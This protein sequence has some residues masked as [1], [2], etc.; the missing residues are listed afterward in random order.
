MLPRSQRLRASAFT[1]A[2]QNGRVLRHPLFQ[3]RVYRRQDGNL[4]VRAAFVAPKKLGKATLRNRTRRRIGE[5]YRLSAAQHDPR[6]Q[7]CDL[8]FLAAAAAVT[9]D[10]AQLDDAITQLLARAAHTMDVKR[11]PAQE[12]AQKGAQDETA[13]VLRTSL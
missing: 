8:I 4:T 1:V 13:N 2:F 11:A 6:L 3:L 9:A 7:G 10:T 12:G 5:R